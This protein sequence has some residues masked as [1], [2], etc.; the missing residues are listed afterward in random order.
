MRAH[1]QAENT[2]LIANLRDDII[3]KRAR[4]SVLVG[5]G[6]AGIETSLQFLFL[7]WKFNKSNQAVS[8][9]AVYHELPFRCTISDTHGNGNTQVSALFQ[10]NQVLM[11][12]VGY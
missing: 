2:E 5:R 4:W 3:K 8:F 6:F 9:I 1:G 7:L 12:S 11:K 10:E